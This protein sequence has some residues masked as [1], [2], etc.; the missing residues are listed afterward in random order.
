MRN[1][2]A[3]SNSSFSSE[4]DTEGDML[5]RDLYQ[6]LVNLVT[7]KRPHNPGAFS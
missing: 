1:S 3:K 4:M 7:N 2:L 5:A 6:H